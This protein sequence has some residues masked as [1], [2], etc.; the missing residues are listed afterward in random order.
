MLQIII[1]GD[2]HVSLRLP[3]TAQGRRLLSEIAR[4]LHG[5]DVSVRA[6]KAL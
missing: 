6:G 2:D 1:H 4:E 3:K 5:S